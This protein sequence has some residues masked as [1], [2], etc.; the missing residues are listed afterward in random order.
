MVGGQRPPE[1]LE[2]TPPLRERGVDARRRDTLR[3]AK[4]ALRMLLF[5]HRTIHQRRIEDFVR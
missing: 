2:F 1:V 3:D 4:H 5:E